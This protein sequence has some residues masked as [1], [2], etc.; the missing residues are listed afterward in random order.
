MARTSSRQVNVYRSK[1]DAWYI[2]LFFL[3]ATVMI[4]GVIV[5]WLTEGTLRSVQGSA[6]ALGVI[7]FVAWVT[8]GTS[9]TLDDHEL[10][11]RSGPVFRRIDVRTITSMEQ[12][13]GYERFRSSPALSLDRLKITYGAGKAVLISP[14]GRDRFLADLKSRQR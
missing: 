8:F 4:A 11:V 14:A 13:R 5:A 1:I 2:G 3:V 12:A 9:Y 10:L 7:G 6:I